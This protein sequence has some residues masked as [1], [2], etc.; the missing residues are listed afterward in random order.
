M[1]NLIVHVPHAGQA[2]SQNFVSRQILNADFMKKENAYIADFLVDNLLPLGLK[3]VVRFSMSRML[4]DVERFLDAENEPM[5]KYG[6]GAV[7]THDSQG[8]QFIESDSI[9]RQSVIENYYLPHHAKMQ[10]LTDS[11]LQS[12]ERCYILNWHSFWDDYVKRMFQMDDCPDICIGTDERFLDSAWLRATQAYFEGKGYSTSI[13]H[14]FC[15]SFVPSKHYYENDTRVKSLMLE[16][17]KRLYLT[18]NNELMAD[19]ATRLKAA[20]AEYFVMLDG[21]IIKP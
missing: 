21:A 7:Y 5:E 20:V 9:Y 2:M 17:N 18:P 14:P 11:I 6:M 10:K 4:C 3:N 19:K 12:H 8:R 16:F 15:G 13:N 1:N